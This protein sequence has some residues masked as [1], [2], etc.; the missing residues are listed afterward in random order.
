M[1]LLLITIVFIVIFYLFK[2]NNEESKNTANRNITLEFTQS[3]DPEDYEENI[4]LLNKKYTPRSGLKLQIFSKKKKEFKIG[5]KLIT[6]F[7]D[8]ESYYKD[9]FFE[10][11]FEYKDELIAI[12]DEAIDEKH[13]LIRLIR[14]YFSGYEVIVEIVDINNDVF[15]DVDI[16]FLKGDTLI[17]GAIKRNKSTKKRG[18]F[19]VTGFHHLPEEVK[20]IIWKDLKPK[21][22]VELIPD[23][24]NKYDSEAV[25]VFFR[26]IHIGWVSRKY[27]N[28]TLLYNKLIEGTDVAS[29]CIRNKR[30]QDYIGGD[31]RNKYLGMAQFVTIKYEYD[32]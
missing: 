30:D 7:K 22:K 4:E 9:C 8:K 13:Q 20:R 23:I 24:N 31:W 11:G 19:E 27:R 6:I 12:E 17:Q 16:S 3:D 2:K 32:K 21:D 14:A 25:K 10:V 26:E 29:V 18:K 15:L 1:Y 28:K 5:E